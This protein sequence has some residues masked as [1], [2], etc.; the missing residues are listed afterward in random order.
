MPAK[1]MVKWVDRLLG[2]EE[3][4][5]IVA[6]MREHYSTDCSLMTRISAARRMFMTA[7]PSAKQS[8]R[9]PSLKASLDELKREADRLGSSDPCSEMIRDF[10]EADLRT[11]YAEWRRRPHLQP[12]CVHTEAVQRIFAKMRVLP[13]NMDSFRAPAATL[14]ECIAESEDAKLEKSE[15]MTLIPNADKILSKVARV[16]ERPDDHSLSELIVALCIASG[17]RLGEIAS[18]RSHFWAMPLSEDATP[19]K[20]ASGRGN[21]YNDIDVAT[22]DRISDTEFVMLPSGHCLSRQDAV[23]LVKKSPVTN[24]Y[25]RQSVTGRA[26]Q[27]LIAFAKDGTTP[28]DHQLSDEDA[29]EHYAHGVMFSGQLKQTKLK[30]PPPYAIPII[31]VTADRFLVG[32]DKLRA[33]QSGDLV[34]KSQSDISSLYQSNARKYLKAELP[35]FRKIHELRAFYASCV[36]KAFDWKR[37]SEPRVIMYILGHQNMNFFVNYNSVQLNGL[38][39][40]Y[41]EFPV[42]IATRSRREGRMSLKERKQAGI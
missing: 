36:Y 5:D 9:H 20:R 42:Q 21:C 22:L 4:S 12:G 8:N 26:L 32:V 17:R 2:G 37:L 30:A 1:H 7:T 33:R 10:L 41:G 18:P 13:D 25:T 24:P 29:R 19:R 28:S 31:G 40:S 15:T 16:L 34:K 14:Q 35:V 39:A 27:R 3:G 11:M 23:N 6:E 38:T